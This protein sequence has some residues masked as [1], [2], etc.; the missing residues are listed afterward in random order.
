MIKF[1]MFCII[2][3]IIASTLWS[4]QATS[5]NNSPPSPPASKDYRIYWNVPS[6]SCNKY[7]IYFPE[8]SSNYGIIQNLNDTFRGNNITIMY[9]PGN[10]PR[11]LKN[12]NGS[13]TII[14]GG[15]PQRG[16]LDEHL[17]RFR[18]DL[19]EQTD[20]NFSGIGIIDFEYWRPIYRQNWGSALVHYRNY[21]EKLVQIDNPSYDN[22]T[23]R[24]RASTQFHIGA[25]LFL[26]TTIRNA[27][28]LRPNASWGFYNYPE[29]FNLSPGQR[30]YQCDNRLRLDNDSTDVLLP[31]LYPS[32]TLSDEEKIGWINGRLVE[33]RRIADKYDRPLE[34]YPYFWYKYK[35]A[36]DTFVTRRDINISFEEILK[37]NVSGHIIWGSY[38]DFESEEKCTEF[39]NY[40][41]TI[42]GPMMRNIK[43]YAEERNS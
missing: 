31:S 23:L 38:R 33:A 12:S 18:A 32:K 39:K 26:K 4:C 11:L 30:D 43:L 35:D 1:F 8:V 5:T 36:P 29:C 40:L 7:G 19:R 2:F 37:H 16:N 24:R 14:N 22:D 13:F 20:P 21:S 25:R 42:L 34:I 28:R 17:E 6:E 10:F 15:V 9:H 27:K 3:S 41:N